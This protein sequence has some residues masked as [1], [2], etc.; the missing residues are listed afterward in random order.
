MTAFNRRSDL[1]PIRSAPQ[2]AQSGCGAGSPRHWLRGRTGMLLLA[3][4]VMGGAAFGLGWAW[5]GFAAV[6]PLLYVLPCLA[7]FAMCMK[8]MGSNRGAGSSAP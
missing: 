1:S 4:L 5:L 6:L 7:M 2:K 3:A 8:G